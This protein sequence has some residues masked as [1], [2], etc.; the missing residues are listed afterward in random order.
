VDHLSTD[1]LEAG[2]DEVRR[3]PSD[4]G[5]VKL[6]VRRPAVDER[7]VLAEAALDPQAGLVGDTWRLRSSTRT[8]DRSPHPDMQLTVM[9]SR[10]ALL[11]ARSAGRRQLAG[12][13]LY[14]DLDLSVTNLPPG[15]RLA[16]GTAGHRGDQPAAPWL[17]QIRRPLRRGRPAV[18]Q[19]PDR[20]RAAATRPERQDRR[21]RHRPG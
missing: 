2:L 4:R 11:V 12:D 18:R 14:A 17:R 8:A 3:S 15:T 21:F 9:N 7:E 20:P 16:L 13:Q 1:Q 19:F 5:T 6:I 10:A